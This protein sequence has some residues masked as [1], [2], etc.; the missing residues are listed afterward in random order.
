MAEGERLADRPMR[1]V[2]G[3]THQGFV[4]LLSLDPFTSTRTFKAL[5]PTSTDSS[6]RI[7]TIQNNAEAGTVIEISAAEAG[8]FT[9]FGRLSL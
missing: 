8:G 7:L 5:R 6:E 2:L 1:R 4:D 3:G 9:T